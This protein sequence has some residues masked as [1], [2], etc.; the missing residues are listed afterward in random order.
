MTNDESST[1]VATKTPD[2]E[3]RSETKSAEAIAEQFAGVSVLNTNKKCVGPA[4]NQKKIG[5][6][7]C[8][9]G[10]EESPK[11]KEVRKLYKY[12]NG[13]V[14]QNE[15]VDENHAGII[16][17]I[18]RKKCSFCAKECKLLKIFS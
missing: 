1:E 10:P 15:I 18:G 17:P 16:R 12:E 14:V 4:E 2:I 8:G 5:D 3:L 13:H 6:G 7:F 9:L 11:R